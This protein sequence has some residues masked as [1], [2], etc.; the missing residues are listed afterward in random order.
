[1]TLYECLKPMC[2]LMSAVKNYWQYEVSILHLWL[3]KF[4]FS[5]PYYNFILMQAEGL[6]IHNVC[7]FFIF[8]MYQWYKFA[9]K[10]L[11]NSGILPNLSKN[12]IYLFTPTYSRISRKSRMG[13]FCWGRPMSCIFSPENLLKTPKICEN[14]AAKRSQWFKHCIFSF[15][16]G[17]WT[18]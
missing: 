3:Q 4:T 18:V 5:T 9:W 12:V 14:K 13:D 8:N 15:N 17:Y 7:D 6:G 16:L 10:L 2:N 1:M 11:M